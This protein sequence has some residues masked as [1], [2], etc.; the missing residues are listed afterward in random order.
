MRVENQLLIRCS[1]SGDRATTPGTEDAG[2]ISGRVKQDYK[3]VFTAFLLDV[4]HEKN[5]KP[6]PRVV[7]RRAGVS[8][9][10]EPQG[11]TLLSPA[12]GN[13]KLYIPFMGVARGGAGEGHGSPPGLLHTF[14]NRSNFKNPPIFSS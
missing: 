1:G 11:Y 13:H 9:T 12:H 5:V 2:S 10:R 6:P 4:Q 14:L 3:L 8:L 7:H